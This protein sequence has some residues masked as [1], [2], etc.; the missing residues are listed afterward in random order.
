MIRNKPIRELSE[1]FGVEAEDEVYRLSR[2]SF[3]G[4]KLMIKLFGQQRLSFQGA[5]APR[6]QI[7]THYSQ[8]L[9]FDS[10]LGFPGDGSH[11]LGIFREIFF[12]LVGQ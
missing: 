10:A 11:L 6:F 12:R 3:E 5:A 2:V 8:S 9:D 4:M 1:A 7:A